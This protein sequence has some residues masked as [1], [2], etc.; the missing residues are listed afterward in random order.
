MHDMDRTQLES[1]YDALE[2]DQQE[3]AYESD[4]EGEGELWGEADQEGPFTEA[5]E[6]ELA[7]DLLEVTDEAE[8]DQFL[9]SLIKKAGRAV[10]QII[11]SPTGRAL[12]GMLKG[13]AKKALP[14]IGQAVGGRFGGPAGAQLG[15][16]LASTVGGLFGL[17]LEGL[18]LEDQEF[19]VA[20]RFVRFAGAAAKNAA[21]AGPGAS[22][23]AAARAATV[24]AAQ[25]HAPGLLRRRRPDPGAVGAGPSPSGRGGRWVRRG[26]HIVIFNCY[27]NG[28]Q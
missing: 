12:G 26:R 23:Q 13:A 6:M 14:K 18:S 9:G 3:F 19:E 4:A 25:R 1:E 5:E 20:R 15:G 8:L 2:T 16:Q 10:G 28:P 22:P 27:G 11:K 7:A 24:S 21:Q 17:E